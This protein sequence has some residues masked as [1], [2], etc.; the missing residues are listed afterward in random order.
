MT[1][2]IVSPKKFYPT[3][4]A[5]RKSLQEITGERLLI[6]QRPHG[7]KIALSIGQM[8]LAG[9]A[10][11]PL[12]NNQRLV[13]LCANKDRFSSFV[14]E[15]YIVPRF[16]KTIPDTFPVIIRKTLTGFKGQGMILC[17]NA[18]TFRENWH[19][20]YWWT[21]YIPMAK[22][23]RVHVLG[24]VVGRIFTKIYTGESPEERYPIRNMDRGY[25]FSLVG[26]ANGFSKLKS[27]IASLW[28]SMEIEH[29]Y[30]ALDVGSSRDGYVYIEANSVA[31]LANNEN[32][33]RMYAE[34]IAGIIS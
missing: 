15:K 27:Q 32:T 30:F 29:G 20:N 9:S 28:R 19:Q 23:F 24:G 5:L 26:H 14:G 1:R 17:E 13:D 4:R 18:D 8:P 11:L 25:H 21:P 33:C 31:S 6:T 34:Y 16:Y 22:E 3:A 2:Y 7:R 12:V 10:S